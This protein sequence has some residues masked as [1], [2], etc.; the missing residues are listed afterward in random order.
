M[1]IVGAIVIA[2]WSYNLTRDTGRILLDFN[3]NTT[4]TDKIRKMIESDSDSRISDL[5]V[6]RVGPGYFAAIL[7]V[8]TRMPRAPAHYKKLLSHLKE[9][10]HITVEI[11]P[12]P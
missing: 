12:Y 10:C 6:W 7:S 3:I 2:R 8:V 9:L 4:L 5:H 1:G 11:N